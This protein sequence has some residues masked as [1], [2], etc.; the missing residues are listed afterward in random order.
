MKFRWLQ[1]NKAAVIAVVVTLLFAVA[2]SI[3]LL[4][5]FYYLSLVPL[6][7]LVLLLFVVR[8]ETGLLCMALL[9]PFA[10]DMAL[11]PKMELS[12]PNERSS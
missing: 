9:T 6:A 7:G 3:L 10:I 5:D 12:M 4:K 1:E 8:F 2:N 11:M